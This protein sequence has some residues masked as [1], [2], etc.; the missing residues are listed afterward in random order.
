MCAGFVE[1]VDSTCGVADVLSKYRSIQNF[2]KTA[3]GETA[4]SGDV[5]PEVM[6]TYV[7]SCGE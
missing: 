1:Y 5:N 3:P 6:D 2:F 4:P 7:R